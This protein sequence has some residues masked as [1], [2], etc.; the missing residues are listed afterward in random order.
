[1]LIGKGDIEPVLLNIGKTLEAQHGV[2]DTRQYTHVVD[3]FSH[4]PWEYNNHKKAVEM[5]NTAQPF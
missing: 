2:L 1:M 3:A 4:L 5:Y